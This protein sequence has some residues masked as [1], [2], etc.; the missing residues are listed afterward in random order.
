M[1]VLALTCSAVLQFASWIADSGQWAAPI[2][3]CLLI[4]LAMLTNKF[5]QQSN[6]NSERSR[7]E[8]PENTANKVTA[9]LANGAAVP[10]A[11][12]LANELH[13]ISGKPEIG[14]RESDRLFQR[15][16]D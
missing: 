8:I 14:R 10:V 4:V 1:L 5:R 15:E 11:R 16:D 12:R 3:T 7:D 2:N 6:R 13:N 9:K